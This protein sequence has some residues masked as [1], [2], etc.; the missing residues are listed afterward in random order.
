MRPPFLSTAAQ[1]LRPPKMYHLY[2]LQRTLLE[3]LAHIAGASAEMLRHP[4]N[5]LSKLPHVRT[6]GASQALFHRLGKRYPKQPWGIDEVE[7][8]GVEVSVAEEV[9]VDEPFCRLV[10]FVRRS[11]DPEVARRLASEPKVFVCAPLS[12]HHSTLLRDTI[13]TLL[14]D[15]DV[16]VTDWLDARDVPLSKGIFHLDDYVHTVM[17]F[18]RLLGAGSLHVVSVCQPT[19]PVLG[20]V[21]LLAQAGEETPRSLT[22][23][24]GPIDARKSP[25]E[26]N[27]LATQHPIEWFEKNMIHKVPG[28]YAGK[29]RRVYPGFLQ[30]TAFVMMNPK[31]HWKASFRYW[32]DSHKGES[33]AAAREMHE[34]FYDEYNAV[35]D[36]DAAYYL[37]TV[38]LV[39]QEFA[40]ARGTWYVRGARV[41]PAAIEKTALFTIEGEKDDISGL[42]QTEAAHALCTGVPAEKKKH[43][44]AEGAGHY[45]IFSGRKWRDGIYPKVR[46]FIRA[47]GG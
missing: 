28:P 39:F 41:N 9:V 3:P 32:I 7:S 12:G 45:G 25:T 14:Q 29:G 16:Y 46:D 15:H 2:E 30:L 10:H 19:V 24:G 6:F 13:R 11:E 18:L 8:G 20:A 31:N 47:H 22:L 27:L 17:R 34:K 38:R 37:E 43:Y 42:G 40:L 5:P 33:G 44:V 23:M 26:V 36:M 1:Y 35:L 4:R 21:S